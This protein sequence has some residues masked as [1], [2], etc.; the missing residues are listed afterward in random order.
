MLDF[1]LELRLAATSL[2]QDWVSEHLGHRRNRRGGG[3]RRHRVALW[4]H[5][6]V[7]FLRWGTGRDGGAVAVQEPAG[8]CVWPGAGGVLGRAPG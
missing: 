7:N 6:M 1:L 5:E 4:R 2:E 3:H 8:V